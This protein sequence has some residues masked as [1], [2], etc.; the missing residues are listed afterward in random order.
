M[1]LYIYDSA[2]VWI[3]VF[4]KISILMPDCKSFCWLPLLMAQFPLLTTASHSNYSNCTGQ[5]LLP[6]YFPSTSNHLGLC[7]QASILWTARV[8]SSQLFFHCATLLMTL[9]SFPGK[10]QFLLCPY[11]SYFLETLPGKWF[12]QGFLSHTVWIQIHGLVKYWISLS[13]IVS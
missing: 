12:G 10:Q 1:Q 8:S 7:T 13:P 3:I 9:G 4:M 11:I 5:R 6:I 2:W